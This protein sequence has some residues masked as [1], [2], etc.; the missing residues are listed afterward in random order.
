M[1]FTIG[2]LCAALALVFGLFFLIYAIRY[3]TFT[4][5]IFLLQ[6]ITGKAGNRNSNHGNNRGNHRYMTNG[7]VANGPLWKFA[8]FLGNR[9]YNNGDINN[10]SGR[11][12]NLH[13]GN[14]MSEPLVSIHLPFYNERNVAGRILASCLSL[15]YGNYEVIVVDDS[16]D[17]TLEILDRW[18][19]RQEVFNHAINAGGGQEL[20]ILQKPVLKI[21]HRESRTGYKGGALNE[22]LR[23]M[24]PQAEYVLVLDSD[25]IPPPDLIRSFLSYFPIPDAASIFSRILEVDKLFAEG[26]ISVNYLAQRE[27]LTVQIIGRRSI[28][29][30]VREGQAA[31]FRLDQLYAEGVLDA[32][33]YLKRRESIMK[34]LERMGA[35]VPTLEP[36]M[37]R[38][39]LLE[40][41][42]LDQLL[43]QGKIEEYEYIR[44]RRPVTPRPGLFL[45]RSRGP[46]VELSDIFNLDKFYAEGGVV[47]EKWYLRER[48]RLQ[49]RILFPRQ[50]R[51][52]MKASFEL[53]QLYANGEIDEK[54]YSKRKRSKTSTPSANNGPVNNNRRILWRSG[55]NNARNHKGNSSSF[56]QEGH[57]NNKLAAVQGYQWHYLNKS[58][59]WIT[60]GVRA[61]Y[62]GNYV[63]ERTCQELFGFLKMIAGS[64]YFIRADV[65]REYR[66]SHSLTEDWELTCRLY[67]DGHKVLYTPLIQ[68]PAEC[69]STILRLIKQRQRW[70]EGHTYNVRKYFWKIMRSP[71]VSRREKLEFL[72]Y[73]PYYL[74][75]LFFTIGTV[76]WVLSEHAHEYLPFWSQSLGLILVLLNMMSL[77]LMNLVGLYAEE[78]T[79][80]DFS[81]V[82][83]VIA[84]TYILAPFQAYSAL[85]SLLEDKEGQWIRTF[86]TG[87][88]TEPII[89]MKLR[90]LWRRLRPKR[91]AKEPSTKWQQ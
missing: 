32:E 19:Q 18:Q 44:R 59:N 28:E 55:G 36:F 51:E 33:E 70:S 12:N 30:A 29:E 78:T 83:S 48:Q 75:S 69:P 39:S 9:V 42:E 87:R 88:I 53:D 13:S 35:E 58:Q 61:E 73:T 54:E 79:R 23:H 81:G 64:V 6:L 52:A 85:K 76:F 72:Y 31:I 43:A 89:T 38:L 66:W 80:K 2:L 41:F 68:V 77:P 22:A 47:D 60:R 17:E 86:K 8:D 90:R 45:E 40:S 74:Q 24:N 50:V 10:N 49:K 25:F 7:G 57:A 37:D 1:G 5:A 34:N 3:Y 27:N 15:D 65:L 11:K 67:A 63:I 56:N 20:L 91:R 62:S 82:L 16:D 4:T 26:K 21:I 71:H 14:F 46:G 84:L